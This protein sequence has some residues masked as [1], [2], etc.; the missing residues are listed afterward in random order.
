MANCPRGEGAGEGEQ[1][2]KVGNK[3]EKT[4]GTREH[5]P[6]FE[7]NKG[8]RTPPG[9]P[10]NFAHAIYIGYVF[11]WLNTEV[12]MEFNIFILNFQ[13]LQK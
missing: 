12:T 13:F 8:T 2:A 5:K 4:A 6:I 10:S 7:G 1:F 3:S 11:R 9:R